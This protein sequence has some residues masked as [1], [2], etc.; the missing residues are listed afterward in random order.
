MAGQDLLTAAEGDSFTWTSAA[1][2]DTD[3][4]IAYRESKLTF[5]ISAS[6][7][8]FTLSAK[9]EYKDTAE[10]QAAGE[11]L[12]LQQQ[13]DVVINT[14]PVEITAEIYEIDYGNVPA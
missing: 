3:G 8:T 10:T 2:Q 5:S 12:A 6:G 1:V 9:L 7:D 13:Q 14:V 4:A 11:K